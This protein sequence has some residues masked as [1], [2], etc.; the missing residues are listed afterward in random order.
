MNDEASTSLVFKLVAWCELSKRPIDGMNL[1][2]KLLDF[3]LSK[4]QKEKA[5]LLGVFLIDN[6]ERNRI[7]QHGHK[8]INQL[9]NN[10]SNSLN[11]EIVMLNE[12]SNLTRKKYGAL[13]SLIGTFEFDSPFRL[14]DLKFI[15]IL[16]LETFNEKDKLKLK[17][18]PDFRFY[19][20]VFNEV[21]YFDSLAAI[22]AKALGIKLMRYP[23]QFFKILKSNLA[24][25][26]RFVAFSDSYYVLKFNS[27]SSGYT[28]RHF[29]VRKNYLAV[30][31]EKHKDK[32]FTDLSQHGVCN[33]NRRY[34]AAQGRRIRSNKPQTSEI[35][36]I[37]S[38]NNR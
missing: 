5:F 21:A 12:L 22:E 11:E 35:Q 8:D 31:T 32:L 23:H 14:A 15:K 4:H 29:R 27:T 9:I 13:L 24:S 16:F 18:L 26:K 17:R 2:Y 37:A 30:V 3:Y 20:F 25:Y 28:F 33:I 6:I 36:N 34:S 19:C 10:L 7:V 1:L 38:K